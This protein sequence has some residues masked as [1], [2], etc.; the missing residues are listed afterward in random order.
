MWGVKRKVFG[1]ND[2]LSVRYIKCRRIAFFE[3][4]YNY[5]KITS[6]FVAFCK[7][8][9]ECYALRCH[10]GSKKNNFDVNDCLLNIWNGIRAFFRAIK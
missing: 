8:I 5:F 9:S 3:P 1:I 2:W 4:M 10:A 6:A 7:L